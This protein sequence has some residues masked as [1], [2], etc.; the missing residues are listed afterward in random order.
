MFEKTK[1]NE[2]EAKDGPPKKE[3]INW[4]MS[5]QLQRSV[6]IRQKHSIISRN[7]D[8]LVVRGKIHSKISLPKNELKLKLVDVFIKMSK[9]RETFC[10]HSA[11]RG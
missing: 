6:L 1:I 2:K 9:A 5:L 10:K 3:F 11:E 4:S 8:K 7:S